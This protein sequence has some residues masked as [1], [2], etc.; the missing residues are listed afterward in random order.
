VQGE[1]VYRLD[2]Q[3]DRFTLLRRDGQG[4]WMGQYRFG[5]QAY[6][7]A[8]FAARCH[9]HQTA[10]D[11]HFKQ[12]RI[13]TRATPDGRITLSERRLI[14]TT[15]GDRQERELV[16]ET[17]YVEALRELFGIALVN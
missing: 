8:D 3:G 13:C 14:V 12:G 4:T 5:Q 9:Y 10:A 17:E 11:S 1:D 2:A 7:Y 16:T 6:T 15:A